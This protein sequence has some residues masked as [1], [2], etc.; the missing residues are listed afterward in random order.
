R[1]LLGL[2]E[3]TSGYAEVAGHR[4]PEHAD[5]VKRRVGL[6]SANTGVYPQLT[7]AEMLRYFGDLYAVSRQASKLR[8]ERL[9][10]I[11]DFEKLL[12]RPCGV[13]STGQ[14]QRINLARSLIHDPAVVLLDEPTLGLDVFGSQ[15][16][17]EFI[18][19]LQ[20]Q[21]KAVILCTHRLDEAERLCTRIGLMHQGRIVREGTLGDLRSETG[22]A[23]LVDMFL[24]LSDVKPTLR[25]PAAAE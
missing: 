12:D 8:I 3:P 5:E 17:N 23:S 11:L 20:E 15:V 2:L 6:V 7:V 9:A 14:R 16:V 4:L 21:Q 24:K 19:H 1:M 22:C 10:Y 25:S 18:Q 13:L